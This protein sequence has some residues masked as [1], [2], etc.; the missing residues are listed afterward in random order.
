MATMSEV[1]SITGGS[2]QAMESDGTYLYTVEYIPSVTYMR[3]Y[4]FN[5][6]TFSL[7]HSVAIAGAFTP[8]S[9]GKRI[10]ISGGYIFVYDM[11]LGYYGNC[12]VRAY[13]FNGST[14]SFTGS[15]SGG[16]VLISSTIGQF[17]LG[18]SGNY[19]FF[20]RVQAYAAYRTGTLLYNG[21]S[22]ALQ[23]PYIASEI[24]MLFEAPYLFTLSGTGTLKAYTFNGSSFSYISSVAVGSPVLTINWDSSTNDLYIY[25]RTSPNHVIEHRTFNGSVFSGIIDTV[26]E[27][28]GSYLN[29][30]TI[31]WTPV[32]L[33]RQATG[34]TCFHNFANG[35]KVFPA[36]LSA[37]LYETSDRCAG[38]I[39]FTV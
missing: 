34:E 26:S 11:A 39:P 8:G 2:I 31:F 3:A 28:R 10:V 33:K 36:D 27:V 24:P 14:F 12:A 37:A 35:G 22:F 7:I 30:T 1:T 5:G 23:S 38:L 32:Q 15:Y 20:Y 4:S 13:T 25:I 6:T 21:S 16:S 17:N 9:T 19:V 18:V 29:S